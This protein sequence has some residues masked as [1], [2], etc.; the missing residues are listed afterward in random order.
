MN[1]LK[2][3]SFFAIISV[4][5]LLLFFSSCQNKIENIPTEIIQEDGGTV[6]LAENSVI[7]FYFYYPQNWKIDRS[8]AMISIY[9]EDAELLK[10]DIELSKDE[11]AQYIGKPNLLANFYNIESGTYQ[12]AEEFWTAFALPQ[13]ESLYQDLEIVSAEDLTVDKI[14]AKKYTYTC[15]LTGMK[16]KNSQVIF[17]KNNKVYVLLYTAT[18][19]QH[20]KYINVLDKAAETFKF[21]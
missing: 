18:E 17:I 3:I 19:N 16:F 7:D 11:N 14:P 6:L 10:S 5:I 9:I 20:S 1:K 12:T 2:K 4:F 13:Y 8:E 21:K 15:S